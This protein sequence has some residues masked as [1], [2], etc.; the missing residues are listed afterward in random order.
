MDGLFKLST[1]SC[2]EFKLAR[3]R[4]WIH[5]QDF[6]IRL[7]GKFENTS[8]RR[9]EPKLDVGPSDDPWTQQFDI[10]I[11]KRKTI[12]RCNKNL[13]QVSMDEQ[14]DPKNLSYKKFWNQYRKKLNFDFISF[15][16]E[17]FSESFHILLSDNLILSGPKLEQV[18][19]GWTYIGLGEDIPCT[20]KPGRSNHPILVV[21]LECFL[22]IKIFRFVNTP[23]THSWS[24]IPGLSYPPVSWTT[25]IESVHINRPCFPFLVSNRQKGW[26]HDGF[27][28]KMIF[29]LRVEFQQVAIKVFQ[30][31]NIGATRLELTLHQTP[32]RVITRTNPRTIKIHFNIVLFLMSC[33]NILVRVSRTVVVRSDDSDFEPG[34]LLTYRRA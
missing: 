5:G 20:W 7:N 23:G 18:R 22:D 32:T 25:S 3:K 9:F 15:F 34:E 31:K 30:I 14:A 27:D 1:L 2:P 26:W 29:V 21:S 24:G 19:T 12:Y 33:W 8:M 10:F 13:N 28:T 6:T 11:I 17:F 16:V 4:S